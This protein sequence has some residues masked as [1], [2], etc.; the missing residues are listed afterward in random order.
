MEICRIFLG[1]IVLLLAVSASA[2]AAVLASD[3]ATVKP[4]GPRTG[5]F[6]KS[7]L[8]VE[9]DANGANASYGVVDFSGAAFNATG[10]THVSGLTLTLIES[11]A[12]F[13]MPGA[14]DV[15][16]ASDPSADIQP[17]TAT[18]PVYT[19]GST[20]EGFGSTTAFGTLTLLGSIPFTTTGNVNSGMADVLTLSSLPPAVDAFFT[21]AV[22]NSKTIRVVLAPQ[23]TSTAA[24]FA[25]FSNTTATPPSPSLDLITD[26]VP[27][28]AACGVLA[29]LGGTTLLRRRT[30]RDVK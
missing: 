22:N 3:N 8:N 27:E 16:L 26:A 6:G 25:G 29:M 19:A 20:P 14:V 17:T 7:F 1:V 2:S 30:R 21:N 13:T 4:A 12:A 10:A 18:V 5:G 15:Y 9:G 11:N 23:T 28:P 24:T